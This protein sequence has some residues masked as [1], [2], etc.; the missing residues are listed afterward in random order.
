MDA[1]VYKAP[2]SE[3]IT[4]SP[5]SL[6]FYIVSPSKFLILQ[7]CTMGMYSIYW[8]FKH[9]SQYKAKHN[10]EM[11]PIARGIFQIF[12]AHSLFA[13]IYLRAKEK[14]NE[15]SWSADSMAT[16]FVVVS[17]IG[18]ILGYFDSLLTSLL[19]LLPFPIVTWILYRAQLIANL[20]CDDLKGELNSN[21]TGL[22][23]FWILLGL[24]WWAMFL[25][26]I[27]ALI[28]LGTEAL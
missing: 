14:N 25:M 1:D 27:L 9:W 2:E 23:I 5:D 3:I 24:V 13:A 18:A 21:I 11:W 20:A 7:I 17:I 16:I 15:L 28:A 19:S 10:E 6:E 4:E 26:G 8:F 22:N 12:F